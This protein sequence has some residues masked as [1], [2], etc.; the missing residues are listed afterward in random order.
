MF[1]RSLVWGVML[2]SF[3]FVTGLYGEEKEPTLQ[4]LMRKKLTYSENAL[5]G[6]V[7]DDFPAIAKN[8]VALR[9]LGRRQWLQDE[10]PAYREQLKVFWFAS[11]ELARAAEEK[12]GDGAALAFVQMTLSCVNCHKY[13]KAR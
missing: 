4:A 7:R 9:D 3:L 11:E 13:L 8:A 1:A 2:L 12:N 5:A 6:I 10:T